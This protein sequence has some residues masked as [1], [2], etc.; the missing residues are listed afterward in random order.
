MG[1]FFTFF[2]FMDSLC[3]FLASLS[4]SSIR[5]LI[6]H[7]ISHHNIVLVS[8]GL[9]GS[10]F[11]LSNLMSPNILYYTNI[12]DQERLEGFDF[13]SSTLCRILLRWSLFKTFILSRSRDRNVNMTQSRLSKPWSWKVCMYWGRP[14]FSSHSFTVSARRSVTWDASVWKKKYAVIAYPFFGKGGYVFGSVGLSNCL[15]VCLFVCGQ[16]YSKK[17][18]MDW[19]EM[20]WKGPGWHNEEL[21]KFWW[22]SRYSKMSKCAK[23]TILVVAQ[24]GR[25]AGNDP[26]PLHL[27]LAFHYQGSTF[28]T[29][30]YGSNDLPRSRRSAV[31]GC[32]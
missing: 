11:C 6:S 16:H 19:D 27:E 8:Y 15:F 28:Y 20:Y 18:W 14:R 29:G 13:D 4:L 12:V 21:I 10:S 1:F 25:G 22:W 17:L 9:F 23:N 3:C 5:F 24:P 31:S 2:A 7:L 26:E 30:Q 32:F